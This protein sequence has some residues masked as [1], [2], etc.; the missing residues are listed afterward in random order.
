MKVAKLMIALCSLKNRVSVKYIVNAKLHSNKQKLTYL[1]L[2]PAVPYWMNTSV[3]FGCISLAN[4]YT[5][6]KP[7]DGIMSHLL[8]LCTDKSGAD[9][10]SFAIAM[11]TW[12]SHSRDDASNTVSNDRIKK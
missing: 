1:V 10:I 6:R 11:E 8:Y 5:T 4:A 9:T 7:F 2:K 12:F 3:V